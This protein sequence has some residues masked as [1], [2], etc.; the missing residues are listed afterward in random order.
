MDLAHLQKLNQRKLRRM[1]NV[2]RKPRRLVIHPFFKYFLSRLVDSASLSSAFERMHM[3][4]E[5]FQFVSD[6]CYA[7][8]IPPRIRTVQRIARIRQMTD[9]HPFL[10]LWF[11]PRLTDVVAAFM[12]DEK[13]AP[14]SLLKEFPS[15]K[16]S[17]ADA[18]ITAQE[19]IEVYS[20]E[21]E[22]FPLDFDVFTMNSPHSFLRAWHSHDLTVGSEFWRAIECLSPEFLSITAVGSLSANLAR[23]LRIGDA[24]P[25]LIIIDRATDILTPL[26]TQMNYE[27][28]LAEF[29]GTDSGCIELDG[30]RLQVLSSERDPLFRELRA[31]NY[32]EVT[33]LLT[34]RMAEVS[35]LLSAGD[36]TVAHFRRTAEVSIANQTVVDHITLSQRLLERMKAAPHFKTVMNIEAT[37][38]AKNAST[39]KEVINDM[40]ESGADIRVLCRLIALPAVLKGA[41][42]DA[43][44]YVNALAFNY[45]PQVVP[46]MMR[47]MS[48]GLLGAGFKWASLIRPFSAFVPDWEAKG[49]QV[50]A[51]YLG[52]APLSVRYVQK[53]IAGDVALVQ[54]AM[55]DMKQNFL[56]RGSPE[57]ED[58]VVGFV[59]GCTHSEIN[60]LRRI[61]EQQKWKLTVVTTDVCSSKSFFDNLADD[62]AGFTPEIN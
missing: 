46:F 18:G 47:M 2:G 39:I 44:K 29:F 59:G 21:V 41:C 43:A 8:L 52:Y 13:I 10:E 25:N 48:L 50:A 1:M 49:D 22:L 27:G 9:R 6:V 42:R 51:S 7:F 62:I 38:L 23:G 15:P 54:K 57:G 30:G 37:L 56:R 60:S 55:A 36:P 40:I 33:E 20:L 34:S 4:D 45:G 12:I 14:A 17:A 31:R 19:G 32:H 35:G 26:I 53:V 16:A 28:L 24:G 61:A 5:K 58:W 11:Q 3:L